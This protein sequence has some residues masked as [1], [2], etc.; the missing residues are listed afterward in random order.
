MA[1]IES[2]TTLGRH[3][4]TRRLCRLLNLSLPQAVG[5]LHL[6]WHW[7]LEF[8]ESG[9]VTEFDA[10]DLAEGAMWEGDPAEFVDALIACGF[11]DRVDD[12][13]VVHD[14]RDYAGRLLADRERKRDARRKA[15][16]CPQTVH[17][18][19]ADSPRTVRANQPTLTVT[20]NQPTAAAPPTPPNGK[21]VTPRASP[22]PQ[23]EGVRST[24]RTVLGESFMRR[25]VEQFRALSPECTH[26]L[27]ASALIEA[28]RQIGPLPRDAL[29][30]AIGATH[31]ALD[32]ALQS[33]RSGGRPI[34]SMKPFLVAI[35]VERLREQQEL[36]HAS[37]T[38]SYDHGA[39][40]DADPGDHRA[41]AT[42]DRGG[43]ASRPGGP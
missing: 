7:V 13:V 15:A 38:D 37:N 17:G 29:R 20:V 39:P 26:G 27:L 11:L 24:Y 43:A 21:A 42:A 30:E 1:W 9:D 8:A 41:A 34:G 3:P 14:W 19:S 32:R 33:E 40:T 35:L 36:R 2:H 5:H 6:F 18:T 23:P 16:D 31:Q 25:M 10:A 22:L 28:E 4:K 12:R